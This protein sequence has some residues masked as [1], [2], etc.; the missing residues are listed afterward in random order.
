M[1]IACTTGVVPTGRRKVA[2]LVDEHVRS[3]CYVRSSWVPKAR[4]WSC[5]DR[6]GCPRKS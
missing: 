4:P 1:Y 5:R 6:L 2:R 3:A